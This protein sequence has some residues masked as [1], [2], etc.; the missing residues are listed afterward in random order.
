MAW[1]HQAEGQSAICDSST[2]THQAEYTKGYTK[3]KDTPS[4]QVRT[5]THAMKM[6][7]IA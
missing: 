4:F 5:L 7:H 3:L 6:Q 1:I 2:L